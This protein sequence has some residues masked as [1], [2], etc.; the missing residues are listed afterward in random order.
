MILV[1]GAAG[2]VGSG[3]VR[4]LRELGAEFRVGY[5][6]RRPEGVA[7]VPIDLDRPESLG[8]ALAG[9]DTVF[10]LSNQVSPELHLVTAA[11]AA[12]VRRI[13]KLSVWD[14]PG[15][16]FEFARWHADVEEA[17]QASGLD[18][19][20]LR[21]TGFMQNVVNHMGATIKGQGAIFQP[22]ADARIA[23][24]DAR[25]V[26]AVAVAALTQPGHAGRAYTLSGPEALSY[27]QV[28]DALSVALGRPIRYVP[29]SDEEYRQGAIGAGIP[30]AYVE[31]LL[32]LA[33]YYRTGA[34]ERVTRDV[35]AVTGRAA[36]RFDRFVTDYVTALR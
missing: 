27:G 2:T 30:E 13:V 29:I 26:A 16:A 4:G 34:S 33:R 11:R 15:R 24:V 32:D 3:V 22:A 12:G 18:W 20:F 28:A 19:T 10:L 23:H 36:T 8:P 21:P 7:G 35:E 5:R 9:A 14:A 1:T 17:I 31:A 25:D 6:N